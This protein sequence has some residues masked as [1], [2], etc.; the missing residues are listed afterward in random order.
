MPSTNAFAIVFRA[1]SY[2]RV[3]VGRETFMRFAGKFNKMLIEEVLY[4]SAEVKLPYNM[5]ELRV[6]K[7]EMDLSSRKSLNPDWQATKKLWAE[8]PELKEEK[9]LVFHLNE[10]RKGFRY[11]IL[12]N[13]RLCKIKYQGIYYFKPTRAFSRELAEI[14]KTNFEIDYYL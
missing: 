7:R 10:H 4:D 5:G 3:N 12:W 6:R 8:K 14:L 2:I 11:K 1:V 9:K 13:K